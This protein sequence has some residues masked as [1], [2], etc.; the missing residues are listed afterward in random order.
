[1]LKPLLNKTIKKVVVRKLCYEKATYTRI[2]L[3]VI[4]KQLNLISF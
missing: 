4:E 1:M 3:S 2:F